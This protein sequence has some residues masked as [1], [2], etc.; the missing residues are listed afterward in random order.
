MP[1]VGI[2]LVILKF[3][4]HSITVVIHPNPNSNLTI[5]F[6]VLLQQAGE[7]RVRELL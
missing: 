7:G 3:G 5:Y 6:F 4:L 2:E 1:G